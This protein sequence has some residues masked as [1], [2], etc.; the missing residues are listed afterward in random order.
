MKERGTF[1]RVGLAVVLSFILLAVFACAGMQSAGGAKST[2]TV[3]PPSGAK[4]SEISIAGAGFKA[5][6]EIDI[7]LIMGPGQR[8]G[9]GTEK[10]DAIHADKSGAFAAKS[11]IPSW[12][13][14]GV[15]DLVVEGS[16]GSLVKTSVEVK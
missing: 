2:V 13:K 8:V 15:Y 16:K 1:P 12:A 6:E 11:N 5:E 7:V 9:L 4:G 14:P 3:T 10:V